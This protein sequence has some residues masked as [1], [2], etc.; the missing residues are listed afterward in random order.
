M[1]AGSFAWPQRCVLTRPKPACDRVLRS[2][3]SPAASP[4][5]RWVARPPLSIAHQPTLSTH[6]RTLRRGISP[7]PWRLHLLHEHAATRTTGDS[8]TTARCPVVVDHGSSSPR[9][10]VPADR[11]K[12][13]RMVCMRTRVQQGTALHCPDLAAD[14]ALAPASDE[15]PPLQR[16]GCGPGTQNRTWPRH[17][18]SCG[19][20]L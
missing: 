7:R 11:P 18:S 10:S 4:V 12:R 3:A 19:Q 2:P 13:E 16:M 20:Q 14:T 1:R 8:Q 17:S 9:G 6:H 15:E 5:G